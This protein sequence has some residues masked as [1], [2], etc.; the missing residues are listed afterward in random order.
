M[1]HRALL[2]FVLYLARVGCTPVFGCWQI[3]LDQG[4]APNKG[5]AGVVHVLSE[6]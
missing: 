5:E 4:Q 6:Q 1:F 2:G 3:G